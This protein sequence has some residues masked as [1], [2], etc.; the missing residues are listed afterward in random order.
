MQGAGCVAGG[1]GCNATNVDSFADQMQ[2]E[3]KQTQGIVFATLIVTFCGLSFA[4]GITPML[5]TPHS[6]QHFYVA[7]FSVGLIRSCVCVILS[8]LCD[9]FSCFLSVIFFALQVLWS[10]NAR[11]QKLLKT[12]AALRDELTT[13]RH[14]VVELEVR[15]C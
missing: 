11:I 2:R 13:A 1:C 12:K 7:C 8:L 4:V 5:R 14:K 15:C 10:R 9:C 3:A 6:P